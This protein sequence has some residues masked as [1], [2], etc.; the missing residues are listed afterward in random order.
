MSG[1]K[2]DELKISNMILNDF[3]NGKIGK[4]S[5]ETPTNF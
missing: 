5:L 4:I 1:G 2:I 3:R